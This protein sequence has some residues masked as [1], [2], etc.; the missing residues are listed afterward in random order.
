[1]PQHLFLNGQAMKVEADDHRDHD[2][3]ESFW[4][5]VSYCGYIRQTCDPDMVK[6][7]SILVNQAF[8]DLLG[9]DNPS[10]FLSM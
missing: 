9:L 6:K 7:D 8:V 1:M 10:D 4:A 5:T 2:V 3:N